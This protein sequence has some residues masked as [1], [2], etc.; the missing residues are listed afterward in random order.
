MGTLAVAFPGSPCHLARLC[1]AT[2][3]ANVVYC[4]APVTGKSAKWMYT[5]DEGGRKKRV[6]QKKGACMTIDSLPGCDVRAETNL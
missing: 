6:G 3:P 4:D 5:I 2:A 1:F